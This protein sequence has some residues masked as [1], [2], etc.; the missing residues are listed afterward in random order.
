[1]KAKKKLFIALAGILLLFTF[2]ILV[3]PPTASFA[4]KHPP[5]YLL[6]SEG[7]I[8]NPLTGE[9]ADQP[10]STYNTC[11][12]CHSYDDIVQGYHFQMGAKSVSDHYSKE[13]PWVL[14]DGMFGKF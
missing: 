10:Y 13:Q 8:I 5:F 12:M 4:G 14:S 6:N 2:Q 1:M 3:I 7:D 9:N 11:D